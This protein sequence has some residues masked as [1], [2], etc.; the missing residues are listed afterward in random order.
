MK[1]E[2]K[3]E[4]PSEGFFREEGGKKHNPDASLDDTWEAP[5]L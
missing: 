4:R 1:K 2:R 3:K 5:A